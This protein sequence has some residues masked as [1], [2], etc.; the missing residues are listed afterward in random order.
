[1]S[2]RKP[3]TPQLELKFS[4]KPDPTIRRV[5]DLASARTR[6]HLKQRNTL[7]EAIISRAAH[8]LGPAKKNEA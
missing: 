7:Y 6:V 8:L 2:T 1:M 3:P 4:C 5:I